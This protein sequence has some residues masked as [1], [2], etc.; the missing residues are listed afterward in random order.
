MAFPK[1]YR[2]L[3]RLQESMLPVYTRIL[4]YWIF[5]VVSYVKLLLMKKTRYCVIR[6]TYF[7]APS[8]VL[9]YYA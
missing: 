3:L 4:E 9:K 1:K 6:H 5:I 7:Y 8:A 2:L